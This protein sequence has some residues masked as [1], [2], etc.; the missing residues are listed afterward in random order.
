MPRERARARAF[1]TSRNL[2]VI[3]AFMHTLLRIILAFRYVVSARVT[4]L[5]GYPRV[6][7]RVI[8]RPTRGAERG[9]GRGDLTRVDAPSRRRA[10]SKRFSSTAFVVRERDVY[11]PFFVVS[12]PLEPPRRSTT[13]EKSGK[14]ARKIE[15]RTRIRA[16]VPKCGRNG[17]K[18]KKRNKTAVDS[19]VRI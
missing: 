18:R 16:Y 14:R 13:S 12:S 17:R 4:F 2:H 10:G 1:H 3:P 8:K 7:V 6:R 15:T 9:R 19:R 11:F 5:A